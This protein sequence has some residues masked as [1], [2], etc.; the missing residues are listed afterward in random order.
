MSNDTMVSDIKKKIEQLVQTKQSLNT[1]LSILN[2]ENLP[3]LNTRNQR[4]RS[5]QIESTRQQLLD[6]DIE[7]NK[8][9]QFHSQAKNIPSDNLSESLKNLSV[10]NKIKPRIS[11]G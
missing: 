8:Q 4:Y 6:I 5:V 9:K 1:R 7:L 11:Q 2:R 3:N 10:S